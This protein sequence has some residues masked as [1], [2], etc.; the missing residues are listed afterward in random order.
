MNIAR[1]LGWAVTSIALAWVLAGCPGGSG[2]G[3]GTGG[4]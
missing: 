4:Y 3:G 2:G 1:R